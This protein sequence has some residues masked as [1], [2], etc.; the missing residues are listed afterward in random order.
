MLSCCVAISRKW[1]TVCALAFDCCLTNYCKLGVLI[2]H[3]FSYPFTSVSQ[4]LRQ[5][6]WCGQLV[7]HKTEIKVSSV[8][9]PGSSLERLGKNLFL[10][11]LKLLLDL[12]CVVIGP[13]S[14]FTCRPLAARSWASEGHLH[15]LACFVH[16]QSHK[17]QYIELFWCL[18]S[19]CLPF[20]RLYL[21][22]FCVCL[23]ELVLVYWAHL[24]SPGYYSFF[25]VKWLLIFFTS[26]KYILQCH[27]IS[28]VTPR[29]RVM[30]Q[31]VKFCL[32]H[33]VKYLACI[34]QNRIE[35]WW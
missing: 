26:A 32:S 27:M 6:Q 4:K 18:P 25:R 20:C 7:A 21:T 12:L 35:C 11:S 9:S 13:K 29:G 17:K 15:A 22:L 34:A 14:S 1:N 23:L 31:A 2:Q 33:F 8:A 30:G 3:P 10:G 24:D 16:L 5:A 19:L 28:E